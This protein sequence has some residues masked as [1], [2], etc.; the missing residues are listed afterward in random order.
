MKLN[1]SRITNLV[2]SNI[3]YSEKVYELAQFKEMSH[4]HLKNSNLYIL[5]QPDKFHGEE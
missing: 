3:Q 5:N 2:L 4:L 1:E